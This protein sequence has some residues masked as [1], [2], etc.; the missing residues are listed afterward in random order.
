MPFTCWPRIQ[1]QG[2]GRRLVCT[3]VSRLRQESMRTLL[4]WVLAENPSRT[5]YERPGGRPVSEQ[6]VTIGGVTLIGVAYGWLS[7][8]TII[9][10]PEPA[11][12]TQ[13]T[14]ACRPQ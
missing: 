14:G 13:M 11:H 8:H 9:G 2:I 3:L 7:S 10:L 12:Q 6:T 4:L 1:G 5:F